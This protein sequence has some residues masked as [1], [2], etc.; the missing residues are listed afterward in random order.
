[1]LWQTVLAIMTIRFWSALPCAFWD[2]LRGECVRERGLTQCYMAPLLD[3]PTLLSDGPSPARSSHSLSNQINTISI[4]KLVSSNTSTSG[5]SSMSV[6]MAT[7]TSRLART[8]SP[9]SRTAGGRPSLPTISWG[10][11]SSF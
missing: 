3:I 4:S 10:M 1:M 7:A 11:S 9:S 6:S 8:S 5:P 2:A